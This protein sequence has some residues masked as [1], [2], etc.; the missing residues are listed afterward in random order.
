MACV[1]PGAPGEGGYF[2]EEILRGIEHEGEVMI[3]S[4]TGQATTIFA[5]DVSVGVCYFVISFH[6]RWVLRC[7]RSGIPRILLN[8]QR[9]CLERHWSF[10]SRPFLVHS[11]PLHAFPSLLHNLK[12]GD[13][14]APLLCNCFA[15]LLCMASSSLLLWCCCL[16]MLL[17]SRVADRHY[18]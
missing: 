9:T 2:T 4:G 1:L 14:A 18:D 12:G 6:I 17:S 15:L 5:V 8:V 10:C 7:L 16:N 11:L 13:P 3:V